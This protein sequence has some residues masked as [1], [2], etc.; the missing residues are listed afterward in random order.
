MPDYARIGA[1]LLGR[2]WTQLPDDDGSMPPSP[3]LSESL[4]LETP[5]WETLTAED[6]MLKRCEAH[7]RQQIFNGPLQQRPSFSPLFTNPP[8]LLR[9][10]LQGQPLILSLLHPVVLRRFVPIARL[11]HVGFL[12]G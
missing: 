12:L 11:Q 4:L 8:Q 5:S 3:S 1:A 6:G 9:Q 10:S 2:P 7:P